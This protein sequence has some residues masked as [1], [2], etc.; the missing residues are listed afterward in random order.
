ML[1]RREKLENCLNIFRHANNG[2]LPKNLY[3]DFIESNNISLNEF[4]INLLEILSKLSHTPISKFPVSALAVSANGN[5]YFGCNLEIK[6]TPL[7]ST[8]HAEQSAINTACYHN[9]KNIS[10]LFVTH[11]PCGHCRQFINEIQLSNNI[12]I[13]VNGNKQSFDAL[14]PLPFGPKDLK[15]NKSL[16]SRE[17]LNFQLPKESQNKLH[18]TALKSLNLAYC[19]YS[20]SHH[21]ISI[22]LKSGEIY[23]GI[24]IENCAYN[25]T[26]SALHSALCIIMIS[27]H[28]F[29]DINEVC[30][31]NTNHSTTEYYSYYKLIL[32]AINPNISFERIEAKN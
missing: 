32:D 24:Q 2:K 12:E 17:R 19:P 29:N 18:L 25:P 10:K 14:L 8:V 21:G 7:N 16:L 11:A 6:G 22:R 1:L 4:C 28:Q 3:V 31:I 5:I 23:Y 26:L 15:I 9:E 27:N 20:N 13:I 30:Y